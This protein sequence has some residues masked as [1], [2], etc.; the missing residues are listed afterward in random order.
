M[1]LKNSMENVDVEE[2]TEN[3][4]E[5]EIDNFTFGDNEQDMILAS[6]D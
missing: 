5:L 2:L 6:D 4:D 1:D 3:F